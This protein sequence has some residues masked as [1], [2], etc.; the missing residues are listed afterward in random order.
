MSDA[1]FA[2]ALTLAVAFFVLRAF[3]KASVALIDTQAD[4]DADEP[5]L[6]EHE[7]GGEA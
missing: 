5:V 3:V 2:A 6:V 7:Y 1:Q 4:D